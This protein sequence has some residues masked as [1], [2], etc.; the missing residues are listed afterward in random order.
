M[1]ARRFFLLALAAGAMLT[2]GLFAQTP[3]PSGDLLEYAR[4]MNEVAVLQ[5]EMDAKLSLKDAER[6]AVAEPA[7]AVEKLKQLLAVV[8]ADQ[9]LPQ[10]RRETLLRVVKDRI[11]VSE[12]ATDNAAVA[13]AE[14][15]ARALAE[16]AQKA[17]DEKRTVE[18]A[19]VKEGLT[20]IAQLR[21][22]GKVADATKQ[23]RELLTNYPQNLA[24]QVLNGVSTTADQIA[25]ANDVRKEK[26]A[27]VAAMMREVEKAA[28]LPKGDIEFPKDWK[29]KTALRTKGQRLSEEEIKVLQA[30]NSTMKPEFKSSRLQDVIDTLSTFTGRAILIEKAALDE[31]NLSYDT[32]I[33]FAPRSSISMRNVLRSVLGQ[34][35][36]TYVVRDNIIQVTSQPRA[37]DMM[38]TKTY[39]VGDIVTISGVFGG[40]PQWGLALDQAQLAQNVA[41]VVEMIQQSIDPQ[42][43]QGRGGFG[44]IGFNIPT[45]SL[46]IRQSA[47]VHALIRG[48]LYK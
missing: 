46:I 43:W 44:T 13:A 3:P 15:K 33:T 30:L 1:F 5:L 16:A 47:E 23:S 25:A 35:G 7:K 37:R 32:P 42:S 20:T 14:A 41:G 39:Y 34:V 31:A 9:K 36:L 2:P 45:M 38:I 27:G 24:V 11:R 29:E 19:K 8:E 18:A 48:G 12:T 10:E 40:A 26:E 22:E 21:K 4:R 17:E 6:L 28:V